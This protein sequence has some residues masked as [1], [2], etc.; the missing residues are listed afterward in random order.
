MTSP[1]DMPL[2]RPTLLLLVVA[3]TLTSR[4]YPQTSTDKGDKS[5]KGSAITG[6]QQV[7]EDSRALESRLRQQ[8]DA[9]REQ[10]HQETTRQTKDCRDAQK[11][12]EERKKIHDKYEASRRSV[13]QELK[14]AHE[15]NR[16][17]E[18]RHWQNA[19][20]SKSHKAVRRKA[21]PSVSV[22]TQGHTSTP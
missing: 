17:R 1:V 2:V 4:G 10:E 14:Q 12:R 15:Q 7:K 8:V 3:L 18:H 20:K 13:I 16:F 22:S 19:D 5:S 21:F 6:S 11:C 9:L